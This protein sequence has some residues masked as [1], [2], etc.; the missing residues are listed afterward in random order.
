MAYAD[1]DQQIKYFVEIPEVDVIDLGIDQIAS[2]WL[3][4]QMFMAELLDLP[5]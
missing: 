2:W 5:V 4:L 1:A 3:E